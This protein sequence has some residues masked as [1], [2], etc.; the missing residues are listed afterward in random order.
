MRP[1]CRFHTTM[2]LTQLRELKSR[3]IQKK[4]VSIPLWFSRNEELRR[5]D[6]VV[7]AVSIPLWFSRN[8]TCRTASSHTGFCFH[9]TMVLTQP[10]AMDGSWPYSLSFP[11]HYGSHATHNPR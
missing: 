4:I 1:I 11:Y 7:S 5:L 3:D 9:T 8:I 10:L 6:N 2:V